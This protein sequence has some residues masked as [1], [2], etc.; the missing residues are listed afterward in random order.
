M[1]KVLLSIM[2]IAGVYGIA[3]GQQGS[4][5]KSTSQGS[6][7]NWVKIGEKSVDLKQEQGIFNWDTDRE[8][9]INA[10]ERYSAIKFKAKDAPVNL[11]N[12]EIVYDNGKKSGMGIN[13]SLQANSESKPVSLD[14]K[15]QLDKVTFNYARNESASVGKA[16]IELW[17]LKAGA[18]S[19]MGQGD[20]AG[21]R[22]DQSDRSST[23][24]QKSTTGKSNEPNR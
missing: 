23:R 5:S 3:F 15:E 10:N 17:G 12:V 7:E 6:N 8:K 19:G 9:T 2:L 21:S 24:E 22:R 18:A 13:S 1:K 14:S 16:K 20:E 11:T 4:V